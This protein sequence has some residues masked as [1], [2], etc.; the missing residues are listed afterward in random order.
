MIKT[1]LSSVDNQHENSHTYSYGIYANILREVCVL[2]AQQMLM[3]ILYAA[4]GCSHSPT[5]ISNTDNEETAAVTMETSEED[6]E[7]CVVVL[8]HGN[9]VNGVDST[10][11]WFPLN[12]TV[13]GHCFNRCVSVAALMTHTVISDSSLE[14]KAPL[15]RWQ[16]LHTCSNSQRLIS[17][18]F[19]GSA[20]S[21]G[22]TC[23]SRRIMAEHAAPGFFPLSG[24]MAGLKAEHQSTM[25]IQSRSATSAFLP[26]VQIFSRYCWWVWPRVEKSPTVH[27]QSGTDYLA[28]LDQ[29]WC[30]Q[31]G[32]NN[33]IRSH[34]ILLTFKVAWVSLKF[35][36]AKYISASIREL[37]LNDWYVKCFFQNVSKKKKKQLVF[38]LYFIAKCVHQCSNPEKSW[39]LKVMVRFIRSSVLVISTMSW[40]W[41]PPMIPHYLILSV[42]YLTCVLELTKLTEDIHHDVDLSLSV[43]VRD[44]V[45][46]AGVDS[47]VWWL[48]VADYYWGVPGRG[49]RRRRLQPALVFI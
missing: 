20:F 15:L 22:H 17:T 25:L 18:A 48:H 45:N 12:R 21:G 42:V 10:W 36:Y 14:S 29:D 49:G 27:S 26:W 2:G 11:I 24:L 19:F 31:I 38:V 9:S 35:A 30:L 3:Y 46:I 33:S 41:T 40:I 47:G 34:S 39:T 6:T 28:W 1:D 5:L 4:Q 37:F 16:Y 32:R 7:A 23:T 8:L 13:Q 44:V 43:H